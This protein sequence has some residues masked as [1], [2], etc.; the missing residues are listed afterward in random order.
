MRITF[1]VPEM[2][3]LIRTQGD[4]RNSVILVL[5]VCFVFDPVVFVVCVAPSGCMS[6]E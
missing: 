1:S 2:D 6:G 3:K 4:K 5:P